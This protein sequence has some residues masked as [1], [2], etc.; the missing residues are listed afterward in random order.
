[1]NIKTHSKETRDYDSHALSIAYRYRKNKKNYSRNHIKTLN[2][3]LFI[4]GYPHR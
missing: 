1:M 2:V 3:T 4:L